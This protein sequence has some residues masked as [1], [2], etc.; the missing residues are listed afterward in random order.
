MLFFA[1]VMFAS[2]GYFLGIVLVGIAALCVLAVA[3]GSSASAITVRGT[4]RF[5]RSLTGR[6]WREVGTGDWPTESSRPRLGRFDF[7]VIGPGAVLTAV[8]AIGLPA[9]L[10]WYSPAPESLG[11]TAATFHD[12]WNAVIGFAVGLLIGSAATSAAVRYGPRTISAVIAGLTGYW[13]APAPF[14][15]FR[16]ATENDAPVGGL[17][18]PT[19]WATLLVDALV[20]AVVF[21]CVVAAIAALGGLAGEKLRG[22]RGQAEKVERHS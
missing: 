6:P 1:L 20:T 11:A 22:S 10:L 17:V 19:P 5:A 12:A 4:L 14:M 18:Q 9:A 7:V 2:S 16:R 8:L 15:I 13:L 21:S 3:S